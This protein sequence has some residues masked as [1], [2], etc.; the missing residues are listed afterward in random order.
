MAESWQEE[1]LRRAAEPLDEE[2]E[3]YLDETGFL[4]TSLK[5]PLVCVVPFIPQ[6]AYRANDQ[7]AR[8]KV[9]LER[10]VKE[11]DWHTVIW[12]HER[13]WRVQAFAGISE[14]LT[15]P[16]YWDVLGEVY[17]DTEN[18]W[19]ESRRWA[20]LLRSRRPARDRFMTKDE[21][22]ELAKLPDT[23]TV[24]RG[25]H[26]RAKK[27]SWAWTLDHDR[28]VWFAQRL[29]GVHGRP[30]TVAT[31]TVA[32]DGVLALLT[33][34]GEDEI[35]VAPSRVAVTKTEEVGHRAAKPS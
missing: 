4:G 25:Y 28:A 33:R 13:P 15:N 16:E 12:L 14:R 23:L 6:L 35:V 34:R 3:P 1:A 31:A 10:A 30:P 11:Q 20:S 21:R 9:A 19:Q 18:F 7:L 26:G 24:Y 8:K 5:H 32:R 22:E 2:L 17:V 29:A 27:L